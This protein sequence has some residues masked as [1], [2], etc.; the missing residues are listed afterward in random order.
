MSSLPTEV[1]S[2]DEVFKLDESYN[3]LL[4]LITKL[5]Q[6]KVNFFGN[7]FIKRTEI[8]RSYDYKD[9]ITQFKYL[10]NVLVPFRNQGCNVDKF[11]SFKISNGTQSYEA[12]IIQELSSKL[13]SLSKILY[14][15]LK[16]VNYGDSNDTQGILPDSVTGIDFYYT[17]STKTKGSFYFKNRSNRIIIRLPIS[18]LML[19]RKTF[20]RSKSFD[21]FI[22]YLPSTVLREV[23]KAKQ[24]DSNRNYS[25]KSH[26]YNS[27][28]GQG[29]K[30]RT[31]RL[32]RLL[33]KLTGKRVDPPKS[34]VSGS[35]EY[36]SRSE[37]E[38]NKTQICLLGL[39]LGI[40]VSIF[41]TLMDKLVNEKLSAWSY[42]A[43]YGLINNTFSKH[44]INTYFKDISDMIN[45]MFNIPKYL[46]DRIEMLPEPERSM[47]LKNIKVAYDNI[48]KNKRKYL[49]QFVNDV[50]SDYSKVK[51][52]YDRKIG[53]VS[54]PLM[55]AV[56]K[57]SKFLTNLNVEFKIG[58]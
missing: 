22:K 53:I 46:I 28:S 44:Y 51:L 7:I 38:A 58:A 6:I 5:H 41:E 50:V 4:K 11:L 20:F 14:S 42:L 17:T 16:Y 15:Q 57:F 34:F 40:P 9:V 31:D 37:L 52:V 25:V 2:M 39:S 43:K 55:N 48:N 23:I 45:S 35:D 30:Q 3:S 12:P 56:L 47:E 10:N 29:A 8:D 1:T 54:N 21:M 32:D 13:V 18:L 49:N 26:S 36:F 27:I 33:K 24:F 19:N